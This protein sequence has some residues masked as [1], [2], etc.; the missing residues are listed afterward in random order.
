MLESGHTLPFVKGHGLGNDYLV[1]DARDLPWP[2]TPRRIAA[3]CERHRS[4]G[5]DG[6][7]VAFPEQR[8][9]QLR[10]FNPDGS[11]AEK[12]GNGLRIF[13]AYLHALGL[14]GEEPFAV[15]LSRDEV[16]LRVEAVLPGGALVVSVD[17]GAASFR[18][19]DVGFRPEPGEALGYELDLGAGQL[20]TINTVS[21]ANPHCVVFVEDL[22]RSDFL[23]RAPLIAT[24]TAFAAG[25]NVQFARVA[26]QRRLEVWIHERGVGE[27][28]ASGTS[29]CAAAAAAVR[30][31]RVAPGELEVAMPG[32]EVQVGV[33]EDFVLRLRGPVQLI[34]TGR[35]TAGVLE[36]WGLLG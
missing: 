15:G 14:V 2:L 25:T 7:L 32:G 6:L 29:A 30:L 4:A 31:G 28:Q 17:I 35:F 3:I 34:C 18:G 8:P 19:A 13:G 9:F 26:G 21:L 12:S 27:T 10:I 24:H 16:S 23:A 36:S 1:V 33:G 20:A 5:S 22:D 11:E